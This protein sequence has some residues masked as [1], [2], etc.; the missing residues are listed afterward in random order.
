MTNEQSPTVIR[1]M[2]GGRRDD[3]N[4]TNGVDLLP[5]CQQR[6]VVYHRC[7]E[8]QYRAGMVNMTASLNLIRSG[9]RSQQK[10][11]RLSVIMIPATKTGDRPSCSVENG[12]KTVDQASQELA[13]KVA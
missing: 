9:A 8:A 1:C 7:T 11:A 10:L 3:Q 13:S 4:L 12:P 2:T 5:A 6:I